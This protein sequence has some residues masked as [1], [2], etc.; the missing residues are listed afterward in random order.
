M[1]LISAFI[2]ARLVYLAAELGIADLIANGLSTAEA[3]AERTGTHAPALYRML[4]ALCAYGVF[5]EPI[6]G[7]FGLG[8]MGAQ[9]RSE[10]SGSVRN[11]ARFFGD[12][13]TWKCLAELEHTMR[14]GETGMRRAFGSTGFEYLATHPAE[15]SIFNAAMGEVARHAARA[16]I[17]QYDFSRFRIILDVGGGNGTFLAEI[18]RTATLAAGILFDVPA[19]LTEAKETLLRADVASRCTVMPGDFFKSVPPGADL[20]ILKNVIHNWNNEQA[21]AILSQCRTAAS[22]QS[23]LLLIERVMPEKMTVSEANQRGATL[24]IR[25][26]TV[27]GGLERTEDEYRNMLVAARFAWVRTI[28]LPAPWDQA[29]VEAVPI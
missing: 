24:D 21:A 25:M 4:R 28:M 13:R 1:D 14:T 29:M 10:V 16:A 11:F 26:L 20:M 3:L 17:A 12:Q 7:Q 9:L 23:R 27:A 18:L 22:S 5:D 2:P 19:G 6:P 15:A 8:P